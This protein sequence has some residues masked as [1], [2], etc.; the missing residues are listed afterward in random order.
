MKF[1]QILQ[2]MDLDAGEVGHSF[3]HKISPEEAEK[4][5]KKQKIKR[6]K[7]VFGSWFTSHDNKKHLEK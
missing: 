1:K 5:Q 4:L 7:K 2:E 6:K 3:I